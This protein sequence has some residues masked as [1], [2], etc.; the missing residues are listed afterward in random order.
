MLETL[1]TQT[2]QNHPVSNVIRNSVWIYAF[3]Q[4]AH[5]VALAV[6]AGAVLIVDFRLMG[7]GMRRQPLAQVAKDA[8]PWLIWSFVVLTLTGVVQMMSNATKEYYSEFFWYKMYALFP[9]LIFTFTIRYMVT[10]AN[11]ARVGHWGKLVALV[12]IGLWLAVT[13]PARLIGL[14]S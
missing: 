13:I 4:A 9:A 12:S 11:E 10:Q 5:L 7:I 1:F 6:F 3:D 2:I 8:Q 14:L